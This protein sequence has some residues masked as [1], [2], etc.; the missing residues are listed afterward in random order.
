M[1]ERQRAYIRLIPSALLEYI[2]VA[3]GSGDKDA[4][5]TGARTA[6]N[7]RLLQRCTSAS[8]VVYLSVELQNCNLPL[9]CFIR[10]LHIGQ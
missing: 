1:R 7:L 2:G 9:T 4:C 8:M 6:D 3:I 5:C 10:C